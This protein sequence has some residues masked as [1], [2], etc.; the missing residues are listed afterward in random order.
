MG[1][2]ISCIADNS[3]Y[4]NE[5]IAEMRAQFETLQLSGRDVS[6]LL[7]VFN[8]VDAD[9]SKFIGCVEFLTLMN[10]ERTPFSERVFSIFDEDH[11]GKIDFR[12]FV[13]SLWNYCTLSPATLGEYRL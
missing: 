1:S 6:K 7:N 2:S 10:V 5:E 3:V 12:E 4:D 11:S 13:L 8:Q 9:H